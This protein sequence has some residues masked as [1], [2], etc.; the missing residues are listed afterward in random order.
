MGY[1]FGSKG[2]EYFGDSPE[3]FGGVVRA[4]FSLSRQAQTIVHT[5]MDVLDARVLLK[6]DEQ[7]E[8]HPLPSRELPPIDMRKL[9]LGI[10]ELL[11]VA[12]SC[13]V[14]TR[15][16][17]RWTLVVASRARRHDAELLVKWAAEKLAPHL[18]RRAADDGPHSSAAGGGGS[19]GSGEVGIP[20][21]WARKARA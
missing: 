10:L 16:N 14:E 11:P 18:S 1:R 9:E 19:G 8:L 2:V 13:V 15:V 5:L 4:T 12:K 7:D 17:D 6:D 3:M 20:V 21:W